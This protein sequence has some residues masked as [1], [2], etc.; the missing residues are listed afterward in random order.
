MKIPLQI[1]VRNLS[2]SEAAEKDIREKVESLNYYNGQIIGCR[3]VVDVP[4]RHHHKGVLYNIRIDLTVPGK[5]F[6]VTREEHEDIYVAIRDGFDAL[7]RRLEDFGRRQRGEVKLHA[8]VSPS[9]K[10][11]RLFPGEGY[12]FLETDDGHEIYFHQ[13]SLLNGEFE[14]LKVGSEVRFVEEAG[15]KGPQASTVRL[16]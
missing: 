3:V 11:I 6:V 1:T 9:A 8:E 16:L 4:H 10:V 15:E 13:N 7:R 12:G 14:Q 2:L 5:E